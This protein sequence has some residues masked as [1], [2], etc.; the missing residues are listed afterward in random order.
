[1]IKL[2]VML[3]CW[4]KI[5]VDGQSNVAL[6]KMVRASSYTNPY[7]GFLVVDGLASS[8]FCFVSQTSG[9][10]W[11]QIDLLWLHL[12]EYVHVIAKQPSSVFNTRLA[13]SMLTTCNNL[14]SQLGNSNASFQCPN[15]AEHA[16][17]YVRV[18]QSSTCVNMMNVCEIVVEG[19]W[20]EIKPRKEN[21]LLR[22]NG[23]MSS[24]I[25]ASTILTGRSY[26]LTSDYAVN[27]VRNPSIKH[28]DSAHTNEGSTGANWIQVDMGRNYYID[29]IAFLSLDTTGV[30]V[31]SRV[32]NFIIGLTSNRSAD[33]APARG[34]YPLCNTYPG[35]VPIAT[36]VSLQCSAN[37][38]AY[39]YLIAQQAYGMS[40]G[41]FSTSELEAYEPQNDKKDKIWCSLQNF[42]LFGYS[43]NEFQAFK[44]LC[45]IIKCL[46]LGEAE[47]DSINFN[48]QLKICQLN[49]HRNGYTRTNLIRSI[50]WSFWN[51]T[52]LHIGNR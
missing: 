44:P 7:T 12:V 11:I 28:G 15:T 25:Y 43:F 8:P 16:S 19:Q 22:K 38:P 45:C 5:F 30:N 6:G 9:Y 39:R 27:G 26:F 46:K 52:Y 47:C 13:N 32:T 20:A 2:I 33:V 35:N 50:T 18:D 49:K 41:Y 3:I 21:V 24:S 17:R 36:R 10:Q 4:P 1:M 23:S 40:D 31:A 37:L 14:T 29:Y 48:Y 42:Q 34:Q 51:A